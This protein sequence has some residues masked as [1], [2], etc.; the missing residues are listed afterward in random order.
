[1]LCFNKD[2]ANGKIIGVNVCHSHFPTRHRTHSSGE[3]PLVINQS[4]IYRQR[5]GPGGGWALINKSVHKFIQIMTGVC[6]IMMLRWWQ[7]KLYRVVTV[8]WPRPGSPVIVPRRRNWLAHNNTGILRNST[9]HGER[10]LR[11]SIQ[12]YPGRDNN[13]RGQVLR[14]YF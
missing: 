4:C 9:Y 5:V 11:W 10:S 7:F 12:Q 13:L 1:M 14:V 2:A 6:M 3:V 8:P